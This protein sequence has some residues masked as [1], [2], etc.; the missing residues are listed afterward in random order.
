MTQQV[1][2]APSVAK[3]EQAIV[4][5]VEQDIEFLAGKSRVQHF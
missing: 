5:F 3:T 1:D 4:S 2:V